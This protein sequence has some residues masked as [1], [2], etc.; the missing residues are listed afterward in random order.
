MTPSKKLR[1]AIKMKDLAPSKDPAGGAS[2]VPI[3]WQLFS[4]NQFETTFSNILKNEANTRNSV[5]Q[6]LK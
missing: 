2:P 5:E 4:N 6:N 1:P 3:P